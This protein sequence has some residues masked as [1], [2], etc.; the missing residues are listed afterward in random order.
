[1]KVK[2]NL[3]THDSNVSFDSRTSPELMVKT[4]KRLGYDAIGFV[5]HDKSSEF[6]SDDIIVFRGIERTIS[7]SPEIHIVD[8]PEMDFQFLAHPSRIMASDTKKTAQRIIDDRNLDGV[9]KFNNG[10]QQYRGSLDAIELSNDDAH[11]LFQIGTSWMELDVED[12]TRGQIVQALKRG[13]VTLKNRRRRFIGT[14]IK[15]V[16]AG[17]GKIL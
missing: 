15:D 8:F 2:I 1:M 4:Y 10:V 9:E 11:N 3:H 13:D 16:T 12:I 17:I 5:G 14:A 6:E 7:E